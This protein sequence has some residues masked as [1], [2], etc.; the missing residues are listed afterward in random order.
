MTAASRIVPLLVITDGGV[1]T[2][3]VWAEVNVAPAS[4]VSELPIDRSPVCRMVNCALSARWSESTLA[5]DPSSEMK[6][7]PMTAVSA[8][9]GVASGAR[10]TCPQLLDQ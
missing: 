3:Q 6:A 8:A 1:N 7:L 10:P 2:D 5:V 4:T 9:C